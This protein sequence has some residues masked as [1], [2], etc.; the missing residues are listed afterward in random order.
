MKIFFTA[1]QRGKEKFTKYYQVIENEIKRLG[2]NLIEDDLLTIKSN[3]FYS[4]F[5]ENDQESHIKF[6]RDELKRLQ[7]SEIN[8]FE[9][10]FHSLSIGFIIEK[11]LELNK[12]TIVLY[13]K[14]YR[15][16]FLSGVEDEKLIV[17]SYTEKDLARTLKNALNE[18]QDQRDKRFN[19]FISPRLLQ[20]LEKACKKEGCTKSYFIRNLILEHKKKFDSVS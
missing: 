7:D 4:Q 6:Y 20:Y 16:L 14:E 19:F 10:S 1:S 9:C 12:P 15:P 8:I 13:H 3:D 17:K 5:K 11:S 2:Y 18:A